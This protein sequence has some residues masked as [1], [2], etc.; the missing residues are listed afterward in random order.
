[1]HLRLMDAANSPIPGPIE[2]TANTL[3]TGK[4]KRVATTS[5]RQLAKKNRAILTAI[6]AKW[7]E[8]GHG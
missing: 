8:A 4:P 6:G 5:A 1:M 7:V 2:P 3:A